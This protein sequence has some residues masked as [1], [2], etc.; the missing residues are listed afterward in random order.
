MALLLC[1]A[2][3]C[4]QSALPDGEIGPP[5][6]E[7]RERCDEKQEHPHLLFFFF[8]PGTDLSLNEGLTTET[9]VVEGVRGVRGNALLSQTGFTPTA[10]GD[11]RAPVQV[12][13][14]LD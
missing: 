12:F 14:P 1:S 2:A 9:R 5:E 6:V 8:T 4:Q 3:T 13:D 11:D 10:T 7:E